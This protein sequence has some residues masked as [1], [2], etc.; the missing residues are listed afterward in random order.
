[1]RRTI[2]QR[3]GQ[4][5]AADSVFS[6][7][8]IPFFMVSQNHCDVPSMPLE[9]VTRSFALLRS[10]F[11]SLMSMRVAFPRG[12]F[13][14]A[15]SLGTSCLRAVGVLR[16]GTLHW[17]LSLRMAKFKKEREQI[18]SLIPKLI[19]Q[20]RAGDVDADDLN[21]VTKAATIIRDQLTYIIP[22]IGSGEYLK[23]CDYL[24]QLQSSFK[25]FAHPGAAK[26]FDGTITAKGKTV[27][28]L[29]DNMSRKGL[30]FSRAA[31]G[32]ERAYAVIQ[33]SL[34]TYDIQTERLVK[35][36]LIATPR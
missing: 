23:S 25:L 9:I 1:L 7:T 29:V 34:A 21:T 8:Q 13:E 30:T 6:T 26:F 5:V 24:R 2:L 22:E 27:G 31:P 35:P 14:P 15:S 4:D 12:A 11:I 19:R 17:P 28:E 18:D 33:Q 36:S 3:L 10:A 20:A 16:N 32:D